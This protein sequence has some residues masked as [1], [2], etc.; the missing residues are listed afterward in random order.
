MSPELSEIRMLNTSFDSVQAPSWGSVAQNGLP[1]PAED[2][3]PT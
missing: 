3:A 1:G 2:A